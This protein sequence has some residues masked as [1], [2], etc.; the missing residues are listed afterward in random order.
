M[1]HE[2]VW[3]LEEIMEKD[4]YFP[5]LDG[6]EVWDGCFVKFVLDEFPVLAES[7]AVLKI[8]DDVVPAHPAGRLN[9]MIRRRLLI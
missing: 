3:R 5:E 8:S 7:G 2:P 9:K 1:L 4:S 6:V